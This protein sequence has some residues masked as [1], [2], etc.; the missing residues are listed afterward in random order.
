MKPFLRISFIVSSLCGLGWAQ[1]GTGTVHHSVRDSSEAVIP[2]A[3][4]VLSDTA[5][6]V[7]RQTV[8]N[9]AGL[10]VFPGVRPGPHRVSIEAP[11][12]RFVG[13]LTVQVQVDAEVNAV[14]KVGRATTSVAIVD[15]SPVVNTDSATLGHVPE[16]ARIEEMARIEQLPVNGRGCQNLLLTKPNVTWSSQGFGIGALVQRYGLRPVTTVL[17]FEGAGVLS[18]AE[19]S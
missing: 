8:A 6:G 2:A 10:F 7:E 17:T 19:A 4:V 9:G 13:A 12:M 18:V 14:M 16:T 15:V 1:S 5:T 11:G 3:S